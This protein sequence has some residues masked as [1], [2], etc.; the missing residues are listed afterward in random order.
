MD[1]YLCNFLLQGGSF[2]SKMC[3][4]FT[5]QL[6]LE[7]LIKTILLSKSKEQSGGGVMSDVDFYTQELSLRGYEF[8]PEAVSIAL[9]TLKDLD[10]DSLLYGYE[11]MSDGAKKLSM[12]C[13][14]FYREL[15]ELVLKRQEDTEKH[16]PFRENE[17]ECLSTL[18]YG[19][20]VDE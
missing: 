15:K 1:D 8:S 3:E 16:L 2:F 9:N 7:L 12:R 6:E 11:D 4:D 5:M 19:V 17:E 18:L 13:W 14:G 10:V 20:E